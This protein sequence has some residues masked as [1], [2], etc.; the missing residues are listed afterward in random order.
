MKITIFIISL[1]YTL[2]LQ[3]VFSTSITTQEEN[4]NKGDNC[5][6]CPYAG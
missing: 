2:N 6:D 4:K 1:I 3:G 5:R